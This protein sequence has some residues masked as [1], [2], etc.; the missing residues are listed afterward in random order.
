M[1][2]KFLCATKELKLMPGRSL[3]KGGVSVIMWPRCPLR[4]GAYRDKA[5]TSTQWRNDP[6]TT[7]RL[8]AVSSGC[9]TGWPTSP[10]RCY[11]CDHHPRGCGRYPTSCRH[12]RRR[13]YHRHRCHHR[14]C[15]PSHC[16]HRFH[17]RRSSRYRLRCR[18]RDR[19][20]GRCR[21]HTASRRA[22]WRLW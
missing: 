1:S 18:H 17:C 20:R 16:H 7:G 3:K 15:R 13:C 6:L 9:S 11:G 19:G 2:L 14:R 4:I 22:P 21:N 5:S 10:S 8:G 12:H